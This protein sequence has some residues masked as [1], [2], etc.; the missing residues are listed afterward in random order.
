M[1]TPKSKSQAEVAASLEPAL[2]EVFTQLVSDYNRAKDIHVPNYTGG[3]SFKI[4][5]ELVR[6]G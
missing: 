5:G 3:A 2:R 6:Q 1:A 4:L